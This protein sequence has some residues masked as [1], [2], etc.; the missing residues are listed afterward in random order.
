MG[1]CTCTPKD[2]QLRPITQEPK[3]CT[4][5]ELPHTLCSSN[6]SWW[7][8]TAREGGDDVLI[9]EA[10]SVADYF[11]WPALVSRASPCVQV[12]L[13]RETRAAFGHTFNY[14]RSLLTQTA[15]KCTVSLISIEQS[16]VIRCV[17]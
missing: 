14:A 2:Q 6:H 9:K 7:L 12:R 15:R 8:R 11:V 3:C 16:Q 13:A 1:V 4:P 10:A 5:T 17:Y